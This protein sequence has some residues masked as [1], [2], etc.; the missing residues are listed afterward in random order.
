MENQKN[1]TGIGF[2]QKKIKFKLGRSTTKG[3]IGEK[4]DFGKALIESQEALM[5]GL[6]KASMSPTKRPKAQPAKIKEEGFHIH[7]QIAQDFEECT[8]NI[9]WMELERYLTL[10]HEVLIEH[11]E[12]RD[13]LPPEII[14]QVKAN[15]FNP[16][17]SEDI[18]GFN[19][20]QGKLNNGFMM[21]LFS[22]LAER[23]PLLIKRL[24]KSPDSQNP[25]CVEVWLYDSGKWRPF[26]LDSKFPI[27]YVL[28]KDRFGC[29]GPPTLRYCRP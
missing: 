26:V 13:V 1:K 15:L 16:H 27:E 8:R 29:D 21:C 20:M 7:H 5:D 18:H 17:I 9:N 11:T 24:F 19:I 14:K 25:S 2:F 12:E 23:C 4:V 10:N 3:G 22:I 28:P 6:I